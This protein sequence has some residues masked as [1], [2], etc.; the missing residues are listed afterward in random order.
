[1]TRRS[2][3]KDYPELWDQMVIKIREIVG[4]WSEDQ[5]VAVISKVRA[6]SPD[7]VLPSIGRVLDWC[8][9]AQRS[10]DDEAIATVELWQM[11]DMPIVIFADENGVTHSLDIDADEVE[12]KP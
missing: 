3:R 10:A 2:L 5:I 11:E 1:M 6:E 9:A 12:I 8:A 4:D 7:D